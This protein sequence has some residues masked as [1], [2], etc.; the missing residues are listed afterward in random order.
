MWH[1]CGNFSFEDL[2]SKSESYVI[3]LYRK[4]ESLVKACGPVTVIPQKTRIV[5]MDLVRFT[6]CMPRKNHLVCHFWF[7]SPKDNA[8][9]HKVDHLGKKAYVHYI[10][11]ENMDDFDEEFIQWIQEAYWVGQRKHLNK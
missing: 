7:T 2:F 1:S 3:E 11:I 10:R 8:R 6:A 9:F 4:F 5:F